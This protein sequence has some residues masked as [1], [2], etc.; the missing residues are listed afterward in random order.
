MV[1]Q[2]LEFPSGVHWPEIPQLSSGLV[3]G[4]GACFAGRDGV[5]LREAFRAGSNSAPNSTHGVAS[6]LGRD[7]SL[8]RLAKVEGFVGS[9]LVRAGFTLAISPGFSTWWR[10]SPFE[11]AVAAAHTASVAASL[12]RQIPTIPTVVWRSHADLEPWADW[13]SSTGSTHISMDLGWARS[14]ADWRWCIEGVRT[15]AEHFCRSAPH[16]VAN[17]PSTAARLSDL[18]SA[19]P[20]DLTFASQSPWS[21]GQHGRLLLDD[22]TDVAD[23]RRFDQLIETNA[24]TFHRVADAIARSPRRHEVADTRER[25]ARAAS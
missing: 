24:A 16:L 8:R 12:A 9:G 14:D 2:D 22:L 6:L 11:S 5:R 4:A 17:G 7:E 10:R 23:G 13:I 20:G 15:L 21:V 19:W 3:I 25:L 18:R 1:P